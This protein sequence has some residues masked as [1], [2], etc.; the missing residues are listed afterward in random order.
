MK[1]RF[2]PLPIVSLLICES[3]WAGLTC[4]VPEVLWQAPRSGQAIVRQAGIGPCV[5]RVLELSRA[6]LL[7]HHGSGDASSSRAAEL[8]YWL[9]ALG[10]EKG[11]IMLDAYQTG[12]APLL[13]EV[14]EEK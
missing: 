11:R 6:R 10:L 5:D 7:I 14:L 8:R 4:E 12:E 9:M 1:C 2:W 3:A 13:V